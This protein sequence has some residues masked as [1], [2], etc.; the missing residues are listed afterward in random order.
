[1]SGGA[2][3]WTASARRVERSRLEIPN[4]SIVISGPRRAWAGALPPSKARPGRR[5][6]DGGRTA[7]VSATRLPVAPQSQNAP[8]SRANAQ[9]Q[10]QA[11]QIKA[12]GEATRNPKIACQLQRSL[13][14]ARRGAKTKARVLGSK[15][16]KH[17]CEREGDTN[18]D[19]AEFPH[20]PVD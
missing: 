9:V 19:D 8:C 3:R 11:S 17:R 1:M 20:T 5:T 4:D 2:G 16:T 14:I 7:G 18:I 15:W 12:R 13:G 10:L 6:N